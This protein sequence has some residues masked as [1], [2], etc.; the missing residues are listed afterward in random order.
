MCSYFKI[1]IDCKG[2]P[3]QQF[4]KVR[5]TRRHRR[6]SCWANPRVIKI[7]KTFRLT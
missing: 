3:N 5:G 7:I 6:D 4:Q 2:N 1:D